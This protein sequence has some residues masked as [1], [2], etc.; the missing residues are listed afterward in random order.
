MLPVVR[1][2][3]A[4]RL[5]PLRGVGVL[6]AV[7]GGSDSTALALTI[8]EAGARL[9]IAHVHHGIRGAD[10]DADADFVRDLSARLAAPFHLLRADVPSL[11]A[12]SPDSLEMAARRVCG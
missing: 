5:P 9:E 4:T 11:A 2:T 10:A 1:Q 3:I 6:A 12:T 8:A 7:S